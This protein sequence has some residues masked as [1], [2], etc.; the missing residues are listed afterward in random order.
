VIQNLFSEAP[1]DL[2][3]Y[4][5]Y[6]HQN[7]PSFT[8]DIDECAQAIEAFSASDSLKTDDDL[9][10]LL[11]CSSS[12]SPSVLVNSSQSTNYRR[13]DD[14][15]FRDLRVNTVAI[16][17]YFHCICV[18]SDDPRTA[19]SVAFACTSVGPLPLRSF[20][21]FSPRYIARVS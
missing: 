5:L 3:L 2:S 12:P 11:S 6:L 21:N 7:Y 9:V 19:D 8:T 14:T 18:Q 20:L 10:R 1:V 15:F 4:N 17:S 13:S 16:E